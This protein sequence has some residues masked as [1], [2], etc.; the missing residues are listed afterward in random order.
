MTCG[1]KTRGFRASVAAGMLAALLCGVGSARADTRYYAHS[2]FDNSLTPDAYFYSSGRPS[3]P[4]ILEL[5]HGN[6]PVESETF[7]TAPNAL[8]LTWQSQQTGGWDAEIRVVNF[9]NREIRF[10]G[11]TLYFWCYS[12]VGIAAADL[13]RLRL[14]D[15]A[16]NFSAPLDWRQF[17]GDLPAGRW[18]QIKIPLARF[19]TASLHDFVAQN[20]RTMVFSQDAADGVKHTL[21]LD[22][23]RIDSA[24]PGIVARTASVA[25]VADEPAADSAA[26]LK[27]LSTEMAAPLNLSAKG[28][29]RHIDLHWDAPSSRESDG[30]EKRSEPTQEWLVKRRASST[31]SLQAEFERYVI[32]RSDDGENFHAVG[33]QVRGIT[34]YTDFVGLGGKTFYYRVATSDVRY[35]EGQP[36]KVVSAATRAADHPFTDDELLNMLQEETFRYY[37]EGAH[38][39]SGTA[40]ENIPGNDR[41]VATGASGF[42]IMALIVGVERGFI[43]REQGLDRLLQIV[44][45]LEKAP[46][47]HGV[48]PHFMDGHTAQT[49]PVFDMVDDGGDLVETAFLMEGLLTARQ[50]FATAAI[51]SGGVAIERGESADAGDTR[52][53][54]VVCANHQNVCERWSG[55]GTRKR[56]TTRRCIGIGRRIFRGTSATD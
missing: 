5:V 2:F 39:D 36:S 40:L 38:P 45:F 18:V 25:I 1:Y 9:R 7:V 26:A 12:R 10:Q 21:V 19:V 4:S 32:Y 14:E 24:D 30:R 31:D 54:G 23:I 3:G 34:R 22:E 55:T 11:D 48:W 8:R 56:R 35:R 49:L 13:P 46:R 50:Y 52:R 44:T 51:K 17:S 53:G 20:L 16:R 37:W 29:E 27:A 15:A 6:L 41:I 42:G 47:Y 33:M 28:Y 43:T